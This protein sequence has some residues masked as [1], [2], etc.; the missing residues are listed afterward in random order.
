MTISDGLHID[1]TG[2]DGKMLNAA[3]LGE[4]I[5]R[6]MQD[7]SEGLLDRVYQAVL[8]LSR[9]VALADDC[10]MLTARRID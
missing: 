7:A 3:R 8:D 10:M 1:V 5:A 9:D 4:I 6:E 2:A